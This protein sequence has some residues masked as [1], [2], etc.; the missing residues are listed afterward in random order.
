MR[1][2]SGG[3]TK[4]MTFEKVQVGEC[5]STLHDPDVLYL[6]V[7]G[8]AGA[9]QNLR[10]AVCLNDGTML[11]KVSGPVVVHPHAFACSEGVTGQ[12]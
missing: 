7:R 4:Q 12:V 6:K 10:Y 1:V 8:V 2:I 9:P 3:S 5:F 11:H